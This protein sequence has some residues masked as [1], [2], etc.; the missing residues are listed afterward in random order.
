MD[1][2]NY[3]RYFLTGPESEGWGLAVTATGFT[4]VPPGTPYPPS[5]HPSDHHFTWE[6]GR[7]LEALQIVLIERG[8]GVFESDGTKPE[9]LV[10]GTAFALVP[11]R[12]HRYR[13]D[14]QTGWT[15]SW[16]ELQGPLVQRWM[17]HGLF[18]A[19]RLLRV[20]ADLTGM[21]RALAEVHAF[22]R[23]HAGG[24]DP[25]LAAKAFA[26]VAAWSRVDGRIV[27]PTRLQTAIEQAERYLVEQSHA[28][29]DLHQLA[30]SLGVAYSH[31]RRAF[32][33]KTGYAPWQYVMQARLA[34]ARRQLSGSDATLEEI[35]ERL[36]FNSGFHLSRSF[37]KAFGLSPGRWRRQFRKPRP[38]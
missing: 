18:R 1:A 2:P 8:E 25:E 6:R 14:P 19:N 10:A 34:R 35:A 37:K 38:S 36:G 21:G 9:R 33:K 3:F 30:Q 24:F 23:G 16:I 31:F 20:G 28:P 32:R 29:I 26:V 17:Q 11:Q 12:W 15:E 27:A 7:V 13:P 4:R 22:A 5:A